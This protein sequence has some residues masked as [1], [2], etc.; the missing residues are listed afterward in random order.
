MTLTELYQ[1]SLRKLGVLASGETPQADD[2]TICAETYKQL[3]AEIGIPSFY[4]PD[5]AGTTLA[6][7]MAADLTGDFQVPEAKTQSLLATRKGYK[8]DVQRLL[9]EEYDTDTVIEAN[10]F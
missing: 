1:S 8:R 4:V 6:Y 10:Y 2:L 7:I 5:G 9:A 3:C